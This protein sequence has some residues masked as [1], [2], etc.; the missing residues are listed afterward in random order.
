MIVRRTRIA[1]LALAA[2]LVAVG[3]VAQ[4]GM[5]PVAPVAPVAPAAPPAPPSDE[6]KAESGDRPRVYSPILKAL[7]LD[8]DTA[9]SADEVA[10]AAE[11]LKTLDK[12]ADGSV[13]AD[14]LQP[15]RAKNSEGAGDAKPADG[16][17]REAAPAGERPR[18]GGAAAFMRI[19]DADRNQ[20]LS[21]EEIAKAPETLGAL[22]K[23]KDGIVKREEMFGSFADRQGR[24]RREGRRPAPDATEPKAPDA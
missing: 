16:A 8:G 4:Q 11:S 14:E 2:G 3:A 22:D 18:Y 15:E 10:K 1:A 12:N 5:A 20:T 6:N 7:D 24:A 23:D 13:A 17:P 21:P 9:L 19:F